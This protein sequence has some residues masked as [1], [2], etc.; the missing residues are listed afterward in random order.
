MEYYVESPSTMLT[1]PLFL[2]PLSSPI[3]R[4]ESGDSAFSQNSTPTIQKSFHIGC[5]VC[6]GLIA[7]LDFVDYL[8]ADSILSSGW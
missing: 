3:L 8:N 2:S 6:Q 5:Q 1:S 7:V 4:G